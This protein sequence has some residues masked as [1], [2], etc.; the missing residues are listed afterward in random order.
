MKIRVL[1]IVIIALLALPGGSRSATEGPPTPEGEP[2]PQQQQEQQQQ[3]QQ[4]EEELEEFVPS[5]EVSPDLSV[6]FPVD[7]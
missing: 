2:P 4:E 1:A 3:Q 6:S 7:I 5:L